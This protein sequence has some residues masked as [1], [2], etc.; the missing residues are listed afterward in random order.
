VAV[1]K[2]KPG[3][4]VVEFE[5]RGHRV[6]RWLPAGATKAQGEAYELKLRRELIDQGVLGQHPSVPLSKAIDEWVE[7]VVEGRK[8]EDETKNKAALVKAAVSDLHLT[9]AGITEAARS[10]R[11]MKRTK[12]KKPGD[13]PFAAATVNRRLSILKG[14]AKWAWKVQQ[15]TPEN[16]SPY[17]ILIDK[18]KERVRDLTISQPKVERLIRAARNFEARAFIAL[19]AYGLMRRGEIM[20][21]KPEDIGRGLTLPVTKNGLPRVVPILPQLRPFLKA[22]PF[23]HHPRTLYEWFEEARDK[24]G[25]TN[26]VHHDLRRS[27]ATILLNAEVPLEVVAHILG[28]SLEVARKVYARVLNRT[29]AKAMRKGFRPIKNPSAKSRVG[30]SA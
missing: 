18:K 9:K 26:L 1:R 15:W 5:S 27:G 13:K 12:G 25:I 4:Y 21:A 16:L 24:V 3:R 20:R 22:I 19:G 28:D 23:R 17:V 10:V 11:A 14:V 8:D 6:F 2:P 29:A 7:N 30:V